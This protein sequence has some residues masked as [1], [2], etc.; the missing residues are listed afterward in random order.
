MTNR[1]AYT[2]GDWHTEL[3]YTMHLP[4]TLTSVNNGVT[5]KEETML[6]VEMW[7]NPRTGQPEPFYAVRVDNSGERPVLYKTA[8]TLSATEVVPDK[9]VPDW[10]GWDQMPLDLGASLSVAWTLALSLA[11][12]SLGLLFWWLRVAR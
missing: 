6:P 4:C 11:A 7:I 2:A 3:I 1:V 10:G 9:P 12:V 8:V 5:T